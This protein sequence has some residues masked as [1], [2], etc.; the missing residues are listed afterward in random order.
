ML[1]KYI[2][3]TCGEIGKRTAFKLRRLL[4]LRVRLP[5]GVLWT[6]GAKADAVSSNLILFIGSNPIPSTMPVWWNGR[7]AGLRNQ[8]ARVRVRLSGT[9]YVDISLIGKAVVC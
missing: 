4:V 9:P 7:H 5:S 3:Y 6:V 2:I 8:F 1:N